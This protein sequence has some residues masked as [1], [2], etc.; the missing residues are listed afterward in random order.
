MFMDL[1]SSSET[2][3]G[4]LET[5]RSLTPSDKLLASCILKFCRSH[6]FEDIMCRLQTCLRRNTVINL[7]YISLR[8]ECGEQK[9][10]RLYE[11][12]DR[13]PLETAA[14]LPEIVEHPDGFEFSLT[15]QDINSQAGQINFGIYH[16]DAGQFDPEAI[17]MKIVSLIRMEMLDYNSEMH[18]CQDETIAKFIHKVRNPLATILVSSSQLASIDSNAFSEDDRLLA[19]YISSEAERIDKMLT[20][21]AE[22]ARN[23]N[24]H[25][26]TTPRPRG[27]LIHESEKGSNHRDWNECNTKKELILNRKKGM[28]KNKTM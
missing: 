16:H 5:I 27:I 3:V 17:K 28:D 15:I 23:Q 7:A 24:N 21:F 18:C 14:N 4:M 9:A 2:K 12:F 22:T 6:K 13:K 10:S 19:N 1:S 25:S 26:Q 8:L 11:C 20:K